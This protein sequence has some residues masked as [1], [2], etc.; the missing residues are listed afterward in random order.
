[1]CPQFCVHPE[2]CVYTKIFRHY[3]AGTLAAY[4]MTEITF[5]FSCSLFLANR[6]LQFIAD[7]M[8]DC[9]K[10][11][12]SFTKKFLVDDNLEVFAAHEN[13]EQCTTEFIN[14]LLKAKCKLCKIFFNSVSEIAIYYLEETKMIK[15]KKCWG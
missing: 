4:K 5:G 13:A 7:K 8:T 3:S 14:T 12:Q 10:V 9:E 6:Y 11:K 2:E 1:M 15:S